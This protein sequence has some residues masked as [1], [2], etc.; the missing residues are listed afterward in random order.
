MDEKDKLRERLYAFYSQDDGAELTESAKEQIETRFARVFLDRG[1]KSLNLLH[2]LRGAITN[3]YFDVFEGPLYSRKQIANKLLDME[4]VKNKKE[5][6]QLF[7]EIIKTN[8]RHPDI[9]SGITKYGFTQNILPGGEVRY[10]MNV[11]GFNDC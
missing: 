3:A 2:K 4:I 10:Q 11:Y 7:P 9:S 5:A 6:T 8:Y 1:S